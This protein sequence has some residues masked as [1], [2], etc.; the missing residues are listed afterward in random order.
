M[1]IYLAI[2]VS[3]PNLFWWHAGCNVVPF[4]NTVR[5]IEANGVEGVSKGLISN[6]RTAKSDD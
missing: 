4:D 6:A 5:S 3:I 1:H 2:D